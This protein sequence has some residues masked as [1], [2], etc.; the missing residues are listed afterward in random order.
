[1][2]KR[3]HFRQ[4]FLLSVAHRR[5]RHLAGSFLAFSRSVNWLLLLKLGGLGAGACTLLLWQWQLLLAT[6]IG[7]AVM[8]GVYGLYAVPWQQYLEEFYR[9]WQGEYRRFSV[10]VL[11]GSGAVCASYLA[12][13]LWQSI[14]NHWVAFALMLQG[15]MV[16]AIL[17]LSV[18]KN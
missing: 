15:A 1:M 6:S 3:S 5:R 8:A 14:E 2:P 11:S 10:S 18:G 12:I 17:L 9:L 7:I 16:G 13:A 4:P